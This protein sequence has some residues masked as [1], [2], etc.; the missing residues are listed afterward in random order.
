M[1]ESGRVRRGVTYSHIAAGYG[2]RRCVAAA[3]MKCTGI[4]SPFGRFHILVDV[5]AARKNLFLA[6]GWKLSA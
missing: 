4:R 2:R 6:V 1:D 3:A 5:R